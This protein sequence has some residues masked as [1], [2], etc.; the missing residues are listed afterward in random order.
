MFGNKNKEFNQKMN[1]IEEVNH[2]EDSKLRNAQDNFLERIN[3]DKELDVARYHAIR[4]EI[5][6]D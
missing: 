6:D 5:N 1:Y 4:R 2:T 3:K